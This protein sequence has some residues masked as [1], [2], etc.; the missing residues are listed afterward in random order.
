M[1]LNGGLDSENML[2]HKY[3]LQ[4]LN[5]LGNLIHAT[6]FIYWDFSLYSK[7]LIDLR[8]RLHHSVLHTSRLR[9]IKRGLYKGHL[10]WPASVSLGQGQS[11]HG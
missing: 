1:L 11:M 7:I 8:Y 10:D 9:F 4:E 2:L 5:L 3:T 6:L